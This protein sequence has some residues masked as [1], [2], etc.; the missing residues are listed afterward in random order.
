LLPQI[1][2]DL[3]LSITKLQKRNASR[4]GTGVC[5]TGNAVRP[6]IRPWYAG[7]QRGSSRN[8]GLLFGEKQHVRRPNPSSGSPRFS[9]P[10]AEALHPC[11]R[12][13][14]GNV[15]MKD[16]KEMNARSNATRSIF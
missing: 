11:A 9:G 10:Q 15:L 14:Y 7:C 3:R 4:Y 13:I 2:A 6:L 16:E 5:A 1:N 12:H 8:Q